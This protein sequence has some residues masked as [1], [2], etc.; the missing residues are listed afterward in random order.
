[1]NIPELFGCNVFNSIQ[2]KKYLPSDVYTALHSSL[3]NGTEISNDIIESVAAAMKE[4][5]I[6]KGATHYTHW[7]QPMTGVT[8]EKHNS[9]LSPCKDGS[10]V[11]EFTAKELIK[12]E[13]DASSFPSGG[14][15]ATFEARG[16]TAWDPTSYAFI[17]DGSLCIPTAF[18][19]YGGEILD[20]KTP[21]LRSMKLLNRQA[22]RILRAL[23]DT[24]TT[25]VDATAGAEQEYF[26]IDKKMYDARE[27]LKL[28][29][30]T[31]FGAMPPKG[32][33]LDDHFFGAIR[34]RVNDF[35]RTL[36]EEL[37]K[38]GIYAKTKHNEVAPS[39]HE[40]A[41]V[42]STVNLAADQNQLT[43]EIMK[44]VAEEKGLACLLHEKPFNGVNGSGKHN[45]W[46]L[47]TSAGKNLLKPGKDVKNN[48]TFLIFL[49]AVISAVD[50]YQDL[51]RISVAGP[52][53]D[54]RLGADEA[55]PAVISMYLG[56]DLTDTLRSFAEDT[57]YEP[58]SKIHINPVA[59]VLPDL[60]KD[61]SDRNRTSPFAFTGDKFEFRM[62]GSD[63]SIAEAN[64]V[65]NTIVADSLSV[66][67]D[68]LEDAPD[69]ASEIS[70]IIKDTYENHSRIIFNGNNYSA[71]WLEEA[72]KRGLLNLRTAAD[73]IVHL[74]DDKNLN[75]YTKH[76]IFS[77]LELRSRRDI[78]LDHYSK[79]VTIE[80]RTMK[81]MALSVLPCLLSQAGS[82]ASSVAAMKSVGIT[83]GDSTAQYIRRLAH[84]ADDV[85]AGVKTLGEVLVQSAKYTQPRE[86][87]FFVRDNLI[88]AM[89]ALRAAVDEY[90][91][92][93]VKM[94]YPTYTDILYSV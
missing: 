84:L 13:S 47:S 87:A 63:V 36:D 49:C 56:D 60:Y 23:G 50:K 67:A 28:T 6:E 83:P 37:W 90:E 61:T 54:L 46:S 72:Q 78:M 12:G 77:A 3:E 79:V 88:P 59:E 33:E 68:R 41:P 8:A 21:L 42:Y 71:E 38:L 10:A 32:Q 7:F 29:G 58:H 2:M 53:N 89:N 14:L 74:T 75:L 9:F 30:R 18:C 15:R 92:F 52:G 39:Q 27:D 17:K 69:I 16:Y 86:H 24:V 11:M 44:R 22:L 73:A 26:L 57:D 51:L 45:N 40:L 64:I 25:H 62:P 66:F 4:W 31:L 94:P 81:D 85:Q 80:A 5:A 35:M 55:P 93:A 70:L 1:M 20:K 34:P 82:A 43:M 65:L 91:P 48:R 76:D 19:S